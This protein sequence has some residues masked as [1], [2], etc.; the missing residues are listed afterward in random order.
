MFNS[1]KSLFAALALG[2]AAS[3]QAANF[4]ITE[5]TVCSDATA[6]NCPL[7]RFIEQANANAE[8][9]TIDLGGHTISL[10]VRHNT[11]DNDFGGGNALP[12]IVAGGGKLTIRN[13]TIERVG[14]DNIRL[15][16]VAASGDLQLQ[17][18]TLRGGGRQNSGHGEG[19]A[20]FS[21]GALRLERCTVTGNVAPFGSGGGISARGGTLTLL[22]STV[23]G[24]AAG[25]VGGGLLVGGVIESPDPVLIHSTVTG[26]SAGF[27]GGIFSSNSRRIALRS[28][29]VSGNTASGGSSR[30]EVWSQGNGQVASEGGNLFG[31]SGQANT[32]G[33]TPGPNDIVP[34][35]ALNTI[36]DTTLASN[37][38][39]TQT[40]A[41]LPGSPAVNAVTA[42]CAANAVDQRGQTRPE[43][44]ACDAGAFELSG[45]YVVNSLSDT[46]DGSCD[47]RHCSLRE[48]IRTANSTAGIPDTLSFNI[49]GG[50]VI[51]LASQLPEI[52]AAGGP[53]QID[54]PT[55][56]AQA[57][58]ID[59]RD[60]IVD[61]NG[62]D[63]VRLMQ[64]AARSV[65]GLNHLTLRNGRT[66]RASQ[67]G[68]GE[69][70]GAIRARGALTLNN[71]V[72][73][74]NEA[75]DGFVGLQGGSGGA[76]EATGATLTITGSTLSNNRA[77]ARG[78]FGG[79]I[80]ATGTTQIIGST[81]SDNAAGAGVGALPSGGNGGAIW[82]GGAL[83]VENS[84]LTNNAAGDAGTAP[85]GAGGAIWAG[86]SLTIRN[87]QLSGNRGGTPASG[88]GGDG[89]A[90][91]ANGTLTINGST[92]SGNRAGNGSNDPGGSGGAIRAT[93]ATLIVNSTV[94]ENLAGASQNSA[95]GSGGAI[96]TS[97]P[98]TLINTTVHG[99]ALNDGGIRSTP[100]SGTAVHVTGA[101]PTLINTILSSSSSAAVCAGFT[102]TASGRSNLA[103]DAS[104]GSGSL[105]VGGAPV[106]VEA[107]NLGT[108]ANNGGPTQTIALK[109]GSVAIDAASDAD[110]AAD[111]VNGVDQRGVAR[112]QEARCDVGAFEAALNDVSIT[113]TA[114]REKV[115]VGEAVRFT[116]T[117]RNLD[118]RPVSGVALSDLVPSELRI[119][120][121]TPGTALCTTGTSN[122]VVC[123]LPTL[124]P[125]A[126]ATVL[127]DTT[128]LSAGSI[129]NTATAG[130]AG[131]DR[132]L[133]DNIS[134][135]SVTIVALDTTPD[136]FSFASRTGV[137]RGST[138]TSA[139]A[140]VSGINVSAPI[141]VS[142]GSLYSIGCTDAGFTDAAGTI[143]NGQTVCVRHTAASGFSADTV[144]TL[145]I[146]DVSATFTSTTEA[147]DITP[148]AFSF[149]N[150]IGVV[151]PGSTQRS[152]AITVSG[153]NDSTPFSVT[154]GAASTNGL[155]CDPLFGAT[156]GTVSNGTQ[157]TVCHIAGAFGD[158]NTTTLTLGADGVLSGT[159]ASF[160]STTRDAVVVPDAFSFGDITGVERGS[161]PTST[162]ITITGIEAAV[163]VSVDIGEVSINGGAFGSGG[164]IEPGQTVQV[165][166]TA[167]ASFA[168][169]VTST[170]T[171]GGVQGTF[172]S[173]TRDAIVVPDAFSF[174]STTNIER[175]SIQ[176]SAAVA[177]TG[178][179][180][181]ATVTV[182]NGTVSINGGAFGSGGTIEPG[183]TEQVRHTASASFAGS[184]TSTVTIGGV[185]GTFSSTTRDAVV[186]PNAFTFGSRSNVE[187]GSQQ[188][189]AAVAI[190]GLEAAATVTVSNG[191]VSING[192]A[193]GNGGTIEPGQT[194][195]VRHTASS[196]FAGTVTSTVT[197]GGMQGTFSSTTAAEVQA[198]AVSLD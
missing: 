115:T 65:L 9:D 110:C 16:H 190:T 7:I 29:L 132:D 107:L 69:G 158:V 49:P 183:Q 144:T 146:G 165:R 84:R 164:T 14:T 197:I 73:T 56:S 189:S 162:S 1:G 41:L 85:G 166:H 133:R 101:V 19:G 46:D 90:I 176:T 198:P 98:L 128:A 59:G 25:S 148:E 173:T 184:V 23:S 24:N 82:V 193:F 103:T 145:A 100:G 33:F 159:S 50:G 188:T 196:S 141:S 42:G 113:K 83:T 154:G 68:A 108:L 15:M 134:S 71:C 111:P 31:H 124:A 6:A 17:A 66:Q 89:G 112:P 147:R 45:S 21:R 37:G 13:G 105:L 119:D 3:A 169:T 121:V 117:V 123:A 30:N 171:I 185:Q 39:P 143:G 161:Q 96:S 74:G 60:G 142:S 137:A 194:V 125:N 34:A 18:V 131:T 130:N 180:A 99:N 156:S 55:D 72:L 122:N 150:V 93:A 120:T 78:G 53:V 44:S 174:P 151:E 36:L 58:I 5:S 114:S 40:H 47:A 136:A 54:G 48:A 191:E 77:G 129:V 160:S 12:S 62:V 70:G 64:T 81:L 76:I 61:G 67:V 91:V 2:L 187:R 118:S 10:S 57:I 138:Q 167:S 126:T 127:I 52:T 32:D 27:G 155:P 35:G 135:A 22:N 86:S 79:A 4:T 149:D 26:N 179:E 178:L 106:T 192:G 102:S 175:D 163:T 186:V 153:V 109:A 28:S 140:T 11:A 80:Y 182:S 87:S 94:A 43:V 75:G 116:L 95:A 139:S 104:C 92:L 88:P 63:G 38:G 97:G 172:S 152:N 20:I 157:I 177:I 170:V 51:A 168:S 195:Q 181:P 8:A